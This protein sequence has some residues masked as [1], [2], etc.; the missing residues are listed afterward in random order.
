MARFKI[1]ENLPI[2]VAEII[3][4][5][6]RDAMTIFDQDMVGDLDPKVVSVCK[7]ED[8]ALITLDLDFSDIRTYPP[9]DCP[10]IIILRPRNQAKPT[11][12]S[13][14]RQLIALL[15]SDEPLSGR[16]WIVQETGLRI[17]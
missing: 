12:L 16:L 8:R 3:K 17:R 14:A 10:G 1:D 11:V 9:A 15:E 7:A 4:A 13:L 5:A 6:G 2:E